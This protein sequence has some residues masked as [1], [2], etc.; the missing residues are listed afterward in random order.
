V[1]TREQWANAFLSHASWP[2]T[3]ANVTALVAIMCAEGSVARNNP[4]D[5]TEPWV[6]ATDLPGNPDGVK[7]YPTPS[8][9]IAASLMTLAAPAYGYPAVINA[10]LAGTNAQAVAVA[11][12]NSEWGTKGVSGWVT[13]VEMTA[14]KYCNVPVVLTAPLPPDPDAPTDIE[15][16]IDMA[17]TDPNAAIR[18]AYRICLHREVDPGG[19]AAQMAYLEGGGTVGGMWAAIQDSPEGQAVIAAERKALGLS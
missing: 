6:G 12:D 3:G 11:W 19:Y 7:E 5:T 1:T 10:F 17:L 14:P 9:G 4:L 2:V 18:I 15:G 13:T 16:I 8:D